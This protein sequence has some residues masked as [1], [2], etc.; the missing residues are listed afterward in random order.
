ML[1]YLYSWRHFD[2]KF[3][4]K[5]LIRDYKSVRDPK[6]LDVYQKLTEKDATDYIKERGTFHISAS[7]SNFL[8][9]EL[10]GSGLIQSASSAS[11]GG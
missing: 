6:I 2:N 4:K 8:R 1:P 3:L 10:G 11:L 5:L 9:A 7:V